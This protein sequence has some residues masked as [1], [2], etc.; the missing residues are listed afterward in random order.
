[1]HPRSHGPSGWATGDRRMS[2]HTSDA[3]AVVGWA[4]A[5]AEVAEE[6]PGCDTVIIDVGDVLVITE[7]FVIISGAHRRAVRGLTER[8]EEAVDACG[9]PKPIH[10]EGLSDHEWVLMDYGALVVHIFT[11]SARDHY[12]LDQLWKD[13]PVLT[14]D[15]RP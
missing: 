3:P 6:G 13:C 8:V 12:A 9:G 4:R 1:M 15:A 7:L 10:I 11:T 14:A 5:A 2:V